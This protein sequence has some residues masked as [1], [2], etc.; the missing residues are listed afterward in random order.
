M[1]FGKTGFIGCGSMGGALARAAA[2]RADANDFM[3]S[4]AS[5]EKARA[6]AAELGG[7]AA[8]NAE[9]AEKCGLIFL[10]VKPKYLRGVL[11][12][13]APILQNRGGG[14]V[15]VS[16]A[17]GVT[18]ASVVEM[19]GKPVPVIRIMPNTPALV[20]CG[21]TQYAQEGV[22]PEQEE[23]FLE[24]MSASGELD[25]LPE[26]LIDAASAVSGCGP[27]FF[28]LAL[29][30][31]ADGGVAAGLPRDKA[32]RYAAKTLEGIGRLALETGSHPGQLKD[33]VT[34]P[35]GST[36]QGVRMLERAGVRSAF[37]EA[38]VSAYEKNLD[39]G[40]KA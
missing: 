23:A 37:F 31:L 4:S 25:P 38:A 12:G 13:I 8:S 26:S 5:G 29:E 19:V 36:I 21:M 30:G 32:L 11:A 14:F 10:G 18:I 28:C 16:M 40:K 3:Y 7:Q 22:T 6:L 17:A 15:L 35:G 1:T 33:S 39:L 24:L 9:I 20:G 27:A 34:S 2:K